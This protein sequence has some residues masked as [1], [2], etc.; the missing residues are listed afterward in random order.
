MCA[1][2][3]VCLAACVVCARACMRMCVCVYACVCNDRQG[4]IYRDNLFYLRRGPNFD[5]KISSGFIQKY[6]YTYVIGVYVALYSY[7]LLGDPGIFWYQSVKIVSSLSLSLCVCYIYFPPFLS[8]HSRIT[9]SRPVSLIRFLS[10]GY[11][12]YF[13]SL[14]LSPSF[15]PSTI[16]PLLSH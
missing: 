4:T 3:C 16:S 10:S 11:F 1:C 8:R 6:M 13:L 9:H 14:S 7:A 5:F 15:P 12:C 2:V